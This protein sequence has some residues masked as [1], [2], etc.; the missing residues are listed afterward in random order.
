MYKII[1]LSGSF[2]NLQWR[3]LVMRIYGGILVHFLKKFL[4]W[5]TKPGHSHENIVSKRP[6]CDVHNLF[7]E[8]MMKTAYTCRKI[9]GCTSCCD[10]MNEWLCPNARWAIFQP[11]RGEL[12]IIHVVLIYDTLN[13]RSYNWYTQITF[14]FSLNNV[15]K[16]LQ[17]IYTK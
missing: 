8:H 4:W 11:Y 6:L 15:L 14:F 9:R 13:Y 17:Y 12:F 5:R 2:L 10:Q 7:R 1:Q 3:Y 16:Y